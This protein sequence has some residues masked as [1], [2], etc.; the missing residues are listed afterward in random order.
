MIF[1]IIA[2]LEQHGVFRNKSNG[3]KLCQL[4]ANNLTYD[5]I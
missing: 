3:A 5:V 4:E 2:T 1:V